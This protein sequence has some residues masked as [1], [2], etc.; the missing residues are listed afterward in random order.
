LK[1]FGVKELV[2]AHCTGLEAVY[3]IRELAGLTRQTC[4]VGS[5]GANYSLANGISPLRVAK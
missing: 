4:T 3:R 1:N 5:V 2:G